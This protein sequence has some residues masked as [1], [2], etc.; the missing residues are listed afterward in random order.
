LEVKLRWAHLRDWSLPELANA[1]DRFLTRVA[2]FVASRQIVLIDGLENILP[3]RD[4]FV[5]VANH[6]SRREAV[7]LPALLMLARGGRTVR[8]LADWNFRLIPG[9]GALYDRSGAITLMRKDARPRLLNLLKPMFVP[10]VPPLEEAKLHLLQGGSVG[11][12]PEGTVN[13]NAVRLLRGRRAAALLSLETQVPVVPVGIR[14]DPGRSGTVQIDSASAMSIHIGRAMTPEPRW[15]TT[16]SPGA[17]TGWNRQLMTEIGRLCG[18]KVHEVE[19]GDPGRGPV[20]DSGSIS[21]PS[22]Q[23]TE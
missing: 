23:K 15:C 8:F 4:P 22:Q 11:I 5:L 2:C 13:R 16:V 10:K 17:V 20:C 1:T 7:F 12:F 14:F 18:K 21:T 3:K 9:A 19:R 6:S